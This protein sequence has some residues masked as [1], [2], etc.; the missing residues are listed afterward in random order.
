MTVIFQSLIDHWN[1]D[2]KTAKSIRSRG[3]IKD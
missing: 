1:F 2:P 3:K